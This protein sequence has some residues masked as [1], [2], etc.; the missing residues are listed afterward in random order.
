MKL[1]VD[2]S[3]NT[4]IYGIFG[5]PVKHSKSPQ[6]QT[7]AFSYLNIPAVYLPFEVKPEDLEK[8]VESIKVLGIKGVNITV[9]H[10]EEVIKYLN[11]VSEEVKY[12]KA[13]NTIKNIDGYLIGYN[14]DAE[15][16]ITGLKQ[17]I[18]NLEGKKVLV[19]GAG[20][21]SRAIIYSLIKEGV[22]KIYQANR[23][24]GKVFKIIEDFKPLTKF[25]E[26]IILPISYDKIECCVLPYVDIIVNTTSV[27]LNEEDKPL[28]DYSK[29]E[30]KHIVID[31]IYKKTPLLKAAENKGCQW[32]DGLPMLLYQ[33]AKAFEIWTGKKAPID[34]M[35][36][37]LLK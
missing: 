19:L 7:S 1:E 23:T 30:K 4:D 18:P 16:F 11:E 10:K 25:I 2:I 9:P 34:V 36:K 27:G 13:C 14:T 8:A 21:A 15:G 3:G 24:L 28:F 20:G 12:I 6:F 17:L 35:K 26:E 33:G 31:I 22:D 29:I 32:Q 5:Y 37:A